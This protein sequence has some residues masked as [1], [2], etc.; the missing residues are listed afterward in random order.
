MALEIRPQLSGQAGALSLRTKLLGASAEALPSSVR[1]QETL[2]GIGM[3]LLLLL[4]QRTL[5][6]HSSLSRPVLCPC[7]CRA[8]CPLQ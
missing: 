2:P 5:S 3:V 7:Q 1:A 8:W 6:S 4:A